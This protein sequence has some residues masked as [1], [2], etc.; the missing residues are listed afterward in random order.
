V[1]LAYKED[2]DEAKARYAAW[3]HREDLGRPGL[4]ITAPREDPPDG[5]PPVMPED[6]VQ[7][8]T[9]LDYVSALNEWSHSRTWFGAEAVPVWHPGYPGHVAIPTLLGCEVLLDHRTGWWQPIL[10]GESW[11]LDD[12]RLDRQSRWW[13]FGEA[14]MAREA[15]DCLGRCIPSIGAFGGCGDT[16][17]AVRGTVPL[18]L[19]CC[20]RP[21]LVRRTE[22]HLMDQWFEVWQAFYER[23][24]AASDG[25]STCWF[26]LWAPGRFYA[27]QN[28][29]SYNISPAM[30][31]ELF[32]PEI[33]R[34]T[35]W[36]DYTV[37]HVDGIGA[38][39][40]VPALC[41][42]PRL[43]A[44]QILPG[45][46]KPS[47]LH[48]LDL[49]RYVQERGKN[50]HITIDWTEVETALKLLDRRGLFIATHCPS[51]AVGRELIEVARASCP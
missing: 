28:D 34:Q 3:W 17:A 33:R 21:E 16:L 22:A 51:E 7:R 13:R 5:E 29:F 42:L 46:G 44:I 6:A 39:A 4:W 36:L 15:A 38:F 20:D 27:A 48:Y 24:A 40:H 37:Y 30:F 35:E 32:L 10:D 50:L 31:R 11:K 23:I 26:A 8:W 18:L 9:D 1:P 2:W 43:Q 45:A 14:M 12:L 49:L 41:E 47:P 19:D 25:G